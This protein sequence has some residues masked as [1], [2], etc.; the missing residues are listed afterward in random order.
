MS[1]H[2]HFCFLPSDTGRLGLT[3]YIFNA[4]IRSQVFSQESREREVLGGRMENA[5]R[6][7][8]EQ[9]LLKSA[10]G[11]P[12]FGVKANGA[13]PT[14]CRKLLS[15]PPACPC[16]TVTVPHAT[17]V[18]RGCQ[19]STAAAPGRARDKGAGGCIIT[20]M[21]G[22]A[23]GLGAGC[24]QLPTSGRLGPR[25]KEPQPQGSVYLWLCWKTSHFCFKES[26]KD[27]LQLSQT[28]NLGQESKG[29]KCL[30][31]NGLV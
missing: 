7:R 19:V 16:Q 4:D 27:L 3:P 30:Q 12:A 5:A 20:G 6:G 10:L 15:G 29:C 14:A 13:H 24:L 31:T 28:Y 2:I 26:K 25:P 17:A 1:S 22:T 21:K 11:D 18:P 9:H 23:G 8:E